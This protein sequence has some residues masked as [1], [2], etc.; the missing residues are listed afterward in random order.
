MIVRKGI[1]LACLGALAGVAG[2]AS[3]ARVL[4]SLLYETAAIDALSYVAA[5]LFVLLVA[6]TAAWLPARRAAAVTAVTALREN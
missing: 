5:A 6:T 2:A 4:Q 3:A 1:R